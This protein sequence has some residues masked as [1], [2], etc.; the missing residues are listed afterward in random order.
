MHSNRTIIMILKT[1]YNNYHHSM[2]HT[3]H[4]IHDTK[5]LVMNKQTGIGIV[6]DKLLL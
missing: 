5:G 2:M 1:N 4:C 6:D 3:V